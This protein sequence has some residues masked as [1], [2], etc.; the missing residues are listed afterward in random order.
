[1]QT[2]DVGD[3]RGAPDHR[4]IAL[5]K[6]VE[7]FDQPLPCHS[8]ANGFRGI[9]PALNCYLRHAGEAFAKRRSDNSAGPQHGLGRQRFTSIP[10]V[11][12]DAIAVDIGYHHA[13][14]NLNAQ[15]SHQF[16]RLRG[17]R[18]RI[19]GQNARAAL[20]QQNPGVARINMP[21]VV[22]QCFVGDFRQGPR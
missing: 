11:K 20:H 15:F 5:V 17:K 3:R 22:L 19:R 4:H 2:K 14:H 1:M 9:R 21:E 16:L 12:G 18:F 10:A 6:I 7:R 8:R 13:L